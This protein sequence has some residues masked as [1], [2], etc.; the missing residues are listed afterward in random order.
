M[1]VRVAADDD[2]SRW[3]ADTVRSTPTSRRRGL[4]PRPRDPGRAAPAAT[5]TT[6][7]WRMASGPALPAR[8]SV[9]LAGFSSWTRPSSRP[10][11]RGCSLAPLRLGPSSAI[12][13]RS[14]PI[15]STSMHRWQPPLPPQL[16]ITPADRSFDPVATPAMPPEDSKVLERL[17]RVRE[18]RSRVR[19]P[20]LTARRA[21]R[22]AALPPAPWTPMCLPTPASGVS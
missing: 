18:R 11:R 21:R 9:N 5:T 15:N 10:R 1:L 6:D 22:P 12:G 14:W 19:D 13:R 16:T 2:G 7:S 8:Y 17:R 4:D 20:A 3:S